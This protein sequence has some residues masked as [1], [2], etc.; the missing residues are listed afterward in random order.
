[1]IRRA[2][3]SIRIAWLQIRRDIALAEI[4][5]ARRAGIRHSRALLDWADQV[6]RYEATI[7]ELQAS[8]GMARELVSTP[9]QTMSFGDEAAE[10]AQFANSGSALSPAP[11]VPRRSVVDSTGQILPTVLVGLALLFLLLIALHLS[12]DVAQHLWGAR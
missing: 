2:I 4:R 11:R 1:V 5:K 7:D 8:T 6:D 10:P 3:T 9:A 12:P